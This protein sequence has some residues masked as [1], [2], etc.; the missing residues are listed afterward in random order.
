VVVLAA[1]AMMAVHV[2]QRCSTA[3]AALSTLLQLESVVTD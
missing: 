3:C 2:L 1:L